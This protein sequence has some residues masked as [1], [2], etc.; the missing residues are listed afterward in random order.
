MILVH[1]LT[2]QALHVNAAHILSVEPT[3]DT[4]LHLTDG[5]RMMVR[6]SAEEVCAAVT[7]WFGEA[8]HVTVVHNSAPAQA[9]ADD[10]KD[11]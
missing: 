9:D 1:R 6:E 10:A 2:G 8:G 5:T 7:R 11:S 3:P 4:L